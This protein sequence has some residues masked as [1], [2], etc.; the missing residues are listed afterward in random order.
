[1]SKTIHRAVYD[2]HS[3]KVRQYCNGLTESET[4]VILFSREIAED[5]AHDLSQSLCSICWPTPKLPK[6]YFATI[7]LDAGDVFD[8]L[9]D[10][11]AIQTAI[12][13]QIKSQIRQQQQAQVSQS[14]QTPSEYENSEYIICDGCQGSKHYSEIQIVKNKVLCNSCLNH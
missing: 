13:D 8:L 7:Q 11:M 5:L 3:H 9:T 6:T 2:R 12:L 1:M 4:S 10:H 14:A